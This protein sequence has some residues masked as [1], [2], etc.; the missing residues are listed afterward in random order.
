MFQFYTPW[1]PEKQRFSIVFRGYKMGTFSRNKLIVTWQVFDDSL[2]WAGPGKRQSSVNTLFKSSKSWKM[3]Y[4]KQKRVFPTHCKRTIK[5]KE[6]IITAYTIFQVL[7]CC[8]QCQKRFWWQR[9]HYRF[10]PQNLRYCPHLFQ[11]SRFTYFI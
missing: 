11:K 6:L 3:R 8:A 7:L 4:L 10:R 1:K 5:I 9:K 2:Q